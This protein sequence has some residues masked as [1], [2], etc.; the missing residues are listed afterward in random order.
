MAQAEPDNTI[1]I[2]SRP[3]TPSEEDWIKLGYEER[4]SSITFLN[5][6]GKLLLALP[7]T[8]ST[9]YLGL[10]AGI[11]LVASKT[12]DFFSLTPIAAWIIAGIFAMLA[13]FPRSYQVHPD[14]P[15]DIQEENKMSI[16]RKL[17]SLRASGIVFLIG[18]VLAA[19]RVFELVNSRS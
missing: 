8:L 15:S 5:D 18:L 3:P 14:S 16:E 9:L 10:L 13:L 6:A 19:W 11:S 1:Q 4:R 7:S 17:F 2:S 12:L